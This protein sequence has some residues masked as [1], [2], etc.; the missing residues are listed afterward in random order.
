MEFK[1]K[2]KTA[3]EIFNLSISRNAKP[4]EK[5]N[6]AYKKFMVRTMRR[7]KTVDDVRS[8]FY[9]GRHA[10]G[11]QAKRTKPNH[12][13]N[14]PLAIYKDT[15]SGDQIESNK[16]KPEFGSW[17]MLGGRAERNKENNALPGKWTAFKIL[18]LF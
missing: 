7:S 1:G 11:P 13:S 16:S 9:T 14:A 6:D 4:V 18:L 12:S 2:M 15:T 3:N 10:L 5:L 17:L 8:F